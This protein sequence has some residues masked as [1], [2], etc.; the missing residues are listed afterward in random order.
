MRR[1]WDMQT[2]YDQT[3][4]I[5]AEALP[6]ML[7]LVQE[8]KARAAGKR[9]LPEMRARLRRASVA[10]VRGVDVRGVL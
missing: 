9:L 6:K 3:G 5:R 2:L 7:R 1:E 10:A 4:V 8:E